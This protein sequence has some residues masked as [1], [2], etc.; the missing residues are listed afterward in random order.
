MKA[1]ST[2]KST[3]DKNMSK[4]AATDFRIVRHQLKPL[5]CLSGIRARTKE[6]L[7][8][9]VRQKKLNKMV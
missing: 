9:F 4:K 1:D 6:K 5:S 8:S 7:A 3:I 2:M